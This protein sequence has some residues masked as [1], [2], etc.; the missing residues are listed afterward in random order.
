MSG[1]SMFVIPEIKSKTF[2]EP[3]D[4]VWND[5]SGSDAITAE[6]RAN[7]SR[8][9]DNFIL[10]TNHG[11]IRAALIAGPLIYGQGSGPCN[12][13]S[14]QAPN[15]AR[16]TLEDKKGF[17]FARGLNAW[18][19]IHIQDLGKLFVRLAEVALR[20]GS[21]GWDTT[22]VYLPSNGQMVQ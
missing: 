1:A 2:G 15:I 6:I 12:Q 16:K 17:Q 21:E 11:A 14:I 10:S 22:A 20:P 19:N 13:R 5:L 7:P 18:S 9:M 3:S 8:E 4:K